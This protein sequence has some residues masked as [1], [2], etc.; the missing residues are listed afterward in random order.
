LFNVGC[1]GANEF[2]V[3]ITAERQ[4]KSDSYKFV[5]GLIFPYACSIRFHIFEEDPFE[6]LLIHVI[7][8]LNT[9][10]IS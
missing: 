4:E 5:V 6:S 8:L 10:L 7:F 9:S 1:G 2:A 3:R